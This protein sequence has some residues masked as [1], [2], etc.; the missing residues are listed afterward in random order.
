MSRQLTRQLALL[1]GKFH[2]Q[3]LE[4]YNHQFAANKTSGAYMLAYREAEFLNG[5]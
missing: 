5:Y 3:A 2:Q 4:K 1:I